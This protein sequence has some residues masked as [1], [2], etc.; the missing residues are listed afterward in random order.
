MC[1][2]LLTI[3]F[4]FFIIYLIILLRIM[5]LLNKDGLNIKY[6]FE[7]TSN[8][9]RKL[10]AAEYDIFTLNTSVDS[11]QKMTNILADRINKNEKD[12]Q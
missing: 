10:L 4:L 9:E 7:K 3:V 2:K 1:F 5:F 6:I 11:L 8:L 12:A